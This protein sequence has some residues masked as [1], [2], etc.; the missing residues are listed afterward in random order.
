[1]QAIINRIL[2]NKLADFKGLNI[3][4]T[5]AVSEEL[6]NMALTDFLN[7]K[8]TEIPIETPTNTATSFDAQELL[9]SVN[10]EQTRIELQ[11]QK[12]NIHIKIT[13]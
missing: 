3:E 10:I 4:G 9:K 1:M 12:M 11:P 6:L 7:P 2:A 13:K 8:T 5:I